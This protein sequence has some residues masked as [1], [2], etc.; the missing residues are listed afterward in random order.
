VAASRDEECAIVIPEQWEHVKSVFDEALR[1]QQGS[2]ADYLDEA[3]A[4]SATQ[5]AEAEALLAA[6]DEADS[7]IDHPAIDFGR[8]DPPALSPRVDHVQDVGVIEAANEEFPGTA[9]FAVHRL[10]GR[11]GFGAVYE[12]YDRAQERL[13]ALKL[14]RR[15]DSGFLY[16]FKREFRALVDIRHPNVVELYELFSENGRWFFTMELIRGVTF[17]QYIAGEGAAQEARTYPCAVARL[18]AAGRQ[19]AQAI[20]TLHGAGLLH[21]DIKPANVLVSHD[22]R[23]RLLD[24][25]LVRE[26]SPDALQTVVRAGTPA[27]VSPEQAAGSPVD[28]ATDW[29]SFGVMLFE[30]LTGSLPS[31]PSLVAGS[32]ET[33]VSPSDK[34]PNVPEDLDTLCADLL[35]SDPAARPSAR[36]ILARLGGNESAASSVPSLPSAHEAF[37]GRESEL[38][39][40]TSLLTLT[41]QG[42]AVVVNLG[43]RSGIG[44]S[45]LLREFRRRLAHNRPDV[46]VLAGRC[47]ES[48]MVPFKALDDVVDRLSRYLSSL[49]PSKAEALAPRDVQCL[50]RMFPSLAQVD[51]IAPARPKPIEIL[52]SEEL[53]QRAFASL[54]ELLSRLVDKH[55]LVLMI[56]DLQW[57]DLDSV[58]FLGRLLKGASPP[59]LLFIASFRSEDAHT[60]PF[61]QSWRSRI[62]SSPSVIVREVELDVLSP[63]ESSDLATRLIAGRGANNQTLAEA[64]AQES[65]GDPFLI[66]QLTRYS[67]AAAADADDAVTVRHVIERR[68]AIL[69][70]D[71]R[72]LLEIVAVASQPL[73]LSVVRRAAG[74]DIDDH[75]TLANLVVERLARIRE[76]RGPREIELYHDRIRETMM[77]AMP[78]ETRRDRHLALAMALEAEGGF[79]PAILARQF[80]EGGD[81]PAAARHM[82]AAAEQASRVLAFDRAAQFYRLALDHGCWHGEELVQVQCKLAAALV[83]VERGTEAAHVYLEASR[84]AEASVAIELKRLAAEQLLRSAHVDEGMELLRSIARQLG[85]RL[86]TKPWHAIVSVLWQRLRVAFHALRVSERP[87]TPV[88]MEDQRVL[89]LYWSLTVGL[90]M[91]DVIQSCDFHTRHM[92]M[93]LR[94]GDRNRLAMSLATE[95]VYRS[96]SG[97]CNTRKIHELLSTARALADGTDRPQ[98]R[99]LIAAMEG[100]C[101]LLIGDWRNAWQLSQQADHILREECTGVAWER[102]T[103]TRVAIAAALH[104][105]EWRKLSDLADH[106]TSRLQDAK[107]RGDLHAVHS[108]FTGAHVCFLAE[109]PWLA[110]DLVHESVAALPTTGFSVTHFSAV[111]ARVDL[112]LYNEDAELAWTLVDSQ[113]QALAGSGLLHV[114][115]FAI[116]ALLLRA[117]ASLAVATVARDD[118]RPYL[119]EAL[120]CARTLERERTRWG[121]LFALL[122]RAGVA[123][124]EGDRQAAVTLLERSEAE[125]HAAHMSHYVATC[126]YRRGTLLGGSEGQA[127]I[128][129]ALVWAASQRV[130]DPPR[131]FD[132][133][134]PGKW[135]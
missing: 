14:L 100:L 83:Q 123:S 78:A 34:A 119:R 121:N 115:Y 4:G 36:E 42:S 44:K 43:G 1:H 49:P 12:C 3:C 31:R 129:E 118:R 79:D 108:M 112:A 93:A 7:L 126:R 21:R 82:L 20:D 80:Q 110:R 92:L 54:L 38:A 53:R 122:V 133:L 77:A 62:T 71:V 76:T 39:E 59:S 88:A 41:N 135:A 32:D 74:V 97:H 70:P 86:P 55:P 125:A 124:V 107:A 10:L 84:E 5:R 128:A 105:G 47:H 52:D 57:G 46:V 95:A 23:V 69:P 130:V 113:W 103:N 65:R 117:R 81:R 50:L 27:Y 51:P 98:T 17:L 109:R 106:L 132:M 91:L 15:R 68:L 22:G 45:A 104:L 16:R 11:G 56:D 19:L 131:I 102:G 134:A 8:S 29:Y 13:I 2:R 66:D 58:A 37:V 116:M 94:V 61:L 120:R 26:S 18:R 96:T 48:E 60:S 6:Y 99:G 25:G 64:I 89:D 30:S 111:Q 67:P 24:F 75:P 33:L 101:A 85:V 90:E 35:R 127:L 9:R 73:P 72:H 40:L 63:S 114:Q 28:Q 87:P